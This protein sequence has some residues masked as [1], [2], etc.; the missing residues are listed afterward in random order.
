MN[1]KILNL[2]PRTGDTLVK[3]CEIC[4]QNFKQLSSKAM[5]LDVIGIPLSKAITHIFDV[6]ELNSKNLSK[7]S[8]V[9]FSCY[10]LIF[11]QLT[12]PK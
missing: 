9:L 5:L 8:K 3:G 4:N 12:Y 10:V 6:L 1:I 2:D 7:L 11:Y